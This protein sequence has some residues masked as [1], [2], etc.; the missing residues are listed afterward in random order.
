MYLLYFLIGF[1]FVSTVL[2]IWNHGH[3][4]VRCFDFPRL[5]L[6]VINFITLG[7]FVYA[8]RS[9]L[10]DVSNILVVCGLL[11]CLA[12]DIYRIHPY[13]W[14]TAKESK[15]YAGE[16][17]LGKI[18][19]LTANIYILNRNYQKTLDLI[20]KR[21]PDVV[22][23]LETD[24]PW[25]EKTRSLKKDYPHHVLLPKDNSYGMLLYSKYP[26]ENSE[27]KYLVDDKIPTIFTKL[28]FNKDTTVHLYCIH[29]RPPRP[30]DGSSDQRDGELMLT[31]EF[32]K[33][34]KNEPVIVTGD[35]ND[36]A[37]SHTT[38]LF[39]RA[40]GLLD[41]R[42]GRGMFNTFHVKYF[43]LRFPLDHFFHSTRLVLDKIERLP[44]VDSDHFPFWASFHIL[45][46]HEKTEQKPEALNCDDK[47]EVEELKERGENWDGPI[48]EVRH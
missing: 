45:K 4:F 43:F 42:V 29:P 22:L 11:A 5:Q 7:L 6:F 21:K 18:S 34:N 16:D 17:T 38:R 9:E 31:T 20:Q 37:W 14:L 35:L 27:V 39:R 15:D 28:Q 26:L 1:A 47:E 25:D 8:T 23:L 2:P 19:F 46:P 10:D 24:D 33:K 13:T 12:L 48:E 41:P 3:W 44:S 36:V 40:S 30:S 32:I